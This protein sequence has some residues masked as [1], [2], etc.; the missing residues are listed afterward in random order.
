MAF[1]RKVPPEEADG[2]LR[3]EFDAASKRS[4]RIWEILRVQSLSPEALRDCMRLYMS[5]MF[6]PSPVPRATRE[7]IAVVTSQVNECHY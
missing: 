3:R 2:V 7:M 6:G 4:G 5:T 1:V